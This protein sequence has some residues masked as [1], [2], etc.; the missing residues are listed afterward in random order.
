MALQKIFQP[1]PAIPFM[2]FKFVHTAVSSLVVL[3]SLWLFVGSWSFHSKQGAVQALQEKI[4][5]R[6]LAIQ[7][8]QQQIQ[9]QQQRI[10]SGAQ[11]AN[12]L[13]PAMLRDLAALQLQNKNQKN[14]RPPQEIRRRGPRRAGTRQARP[15]TRHSR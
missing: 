12:Q 6:Q 3:L 5:A 4:Q 10:D 14:R 1:P 7:S 8:Q 13:G 9:L 11:P 2:P 15:H